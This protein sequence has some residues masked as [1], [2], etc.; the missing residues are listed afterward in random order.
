[1]TRRLVPYLL[2]AVLTLG[3]GLGVGLGLSQGPNTYDA[4][5]E[6]HRD[7]VSPSNPLSLTP[8]ERTHLDVLG[9]CLSAAKEHVHLPLITYRQKSA[10]ARMIDKCLRAHGYPGNLTG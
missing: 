3:V 8:S 7:L 9:V 1:V 4:A 5:T 2:V 6:L 10:Y